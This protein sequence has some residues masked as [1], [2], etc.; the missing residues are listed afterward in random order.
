MTELERIIAKYGIIEENA[1]TESDCDGLSEEVK[2][3]VE[4]EQ[5]EN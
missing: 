3:G 2:L 4:N 5:G 1:V